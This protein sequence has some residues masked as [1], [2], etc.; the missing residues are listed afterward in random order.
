[1]HLYFIPSTGPS[2]GIQSI[3]SE[4]QA[5][6]DKKLTQ[7]EEALCESEI[8]RLKAEIKKQ[9]KCGTRIRLTVLPHCNHSEANGK[10][11]TTNG[12]DSQDI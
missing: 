11:G 1:M 2:D 3:I 10:T 5:L 4:L 7:K 9:C 12:T 8:D 6:L